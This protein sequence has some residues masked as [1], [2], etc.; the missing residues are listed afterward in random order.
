MAISNYRNSFYGLYLREGKING[1][2]KNHL[3]ELDGLQPRQ[4]TQTRMVVRK[5][6]RIAVLKGEG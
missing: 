5:K 6:Q 4:R 1:K 2:K 3:S